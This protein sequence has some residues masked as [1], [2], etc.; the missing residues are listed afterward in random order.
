MAQRASGFSRVP[1]DLYQTPAWVI[2]AL[3]DHIFLRGIRVWE[4][5]ASELL[6]AAIIWSTDTPA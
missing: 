5:A 2:D 6:R 4:P 1:M 3:A